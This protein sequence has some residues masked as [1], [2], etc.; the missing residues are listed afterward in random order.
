MTDGTLWCCVRL[1]HE[2]QDHQW[3]AESREVMPH[4]GFDNRTHVTK[5]EG[6]AGENPTPSAEPQEGKKV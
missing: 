2:D 4:A 5:A 6:D 3:A 1:K